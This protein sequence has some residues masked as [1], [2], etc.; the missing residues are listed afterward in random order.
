M[1]KKVYGNLRRNIKIAF[2]TFWKYAKRLAILILVWQLKKY[3]EKNTLAS[4]IV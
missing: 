3:D 2:V 1:T 4:V